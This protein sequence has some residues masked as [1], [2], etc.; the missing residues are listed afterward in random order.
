MTNQ[1]N[2]RQGKR[3]EEPCKHLLVQVLSFHRKDFCVSYKCT[4]CKE[5][6]TIKHLSYNKLAG[7]FGVLVRD[8]QLRKALEI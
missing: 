1:P 6:D 3:W 7:K 5:G 4:I 2:S 8:K